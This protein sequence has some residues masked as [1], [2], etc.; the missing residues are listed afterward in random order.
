M[1]C[2]IDHTLLL[3][4]NNLPRMPYASRLR[5]AQCARHFLKNFKFI[6][7]EILAHL[8]EEETLVCALFTHVKD[9]KC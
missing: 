8:P 6:D 5:T 2:N 3:V 1:I 9:L 7:Y 4:S